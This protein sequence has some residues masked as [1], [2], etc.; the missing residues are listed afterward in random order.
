MP[1]I[2]ARLRTIREEQKL[3]ASEMARR[4]GV[5]RQ[6]IY[7]I[8]DGSFVP[9]TAIALRL[10]RA[11]D[12]SVEELFS[13][14]EESRAEFEINA[15]LLTVTAQKLNKG[16]PVRLCSVGNRQIA[17]PASAVSHYLPEADGV[18]ESA[19]GRSVRARCLRSVPEKVKTLVIAGC[20]PALSFVEHS[21]AASGFRVVTVPCSSRKALDWL[22]EGRV[23][24]A[25][26][27]LR[28]PGSAEHNVP[29]VQRLFPKGGVRVVTF[30]GWEEGLITK[31]GN[32]KGIRSIADLGHKGVTLFNREKGSGSRALLD[33]GLVKAGIWAKSIAGY[34]RIATGHLPVAYEIARGAADCCVA[35]RSAA[36]CFGLNFVPLAAERFDLVMTEATFESGAGS[37]LMELLN[38]SALRRK[39]QTIAGYDVL[40]TG[41]V[42]V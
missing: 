31:Q 18:L 9:N 33:S 38:G 6:T 3:P 1:E 29:I 23:H 42:V 17:V 26:L 34:E 15:E 16:Q 4:I 35:T 13:L 5:S 11:L 36:R 41:S 24:V 27:H 7:A 30:A 39:L 28:E 8:E 19:S 37:A 25:G 32:P 2:Q 20:D 10:A 14:S 21:L 22:R 40:Q 12:T